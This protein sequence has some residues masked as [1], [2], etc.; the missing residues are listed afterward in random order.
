MILL[1]NFP[2]END[3]LKSE[4]MRSLTNELFTR[5]TH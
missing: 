4:T 5:F 3:F 1:F 2:Y